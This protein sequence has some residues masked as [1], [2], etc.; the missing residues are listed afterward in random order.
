M[1]QHRYQKGTAENPEER[2]LIKTLA[3]HSNGR[4]FGTNRVVD[5]PFRQLKRQVEQRKQASG[6]D[7]QHQ[8]V[9]FR[10]FPDEAE[11]RALDGKAP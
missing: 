8:L 7:K 2:Q 3:Q 9:A 10:V 6:H 1:A 5:D 11:Q 4:A